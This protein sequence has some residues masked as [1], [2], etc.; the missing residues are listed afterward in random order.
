MIYNFL[1]LKIKR[2]KDVVACFDET[3]AALKSNTAWYKC[4]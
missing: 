3:N 1:V 4:K 2:H